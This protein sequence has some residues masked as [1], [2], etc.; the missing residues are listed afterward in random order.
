MKKTTMKAAICTKYGPPEVLQIKKIKKPIPKNNE[1]LIKM[2]ATTAT[3]G[4]ARMRSF[5]VP[6]LFWLPRPKYF[7]FPIV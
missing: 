2:H 4:D 7:F 6:L 3:S 1:V 5:N